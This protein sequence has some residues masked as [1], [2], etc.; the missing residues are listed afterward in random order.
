MEV[1]IQLY[2]TEKKKDENADEDDGK[3][4]EVNELPRS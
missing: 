2:T 4:R 3:R 1:T